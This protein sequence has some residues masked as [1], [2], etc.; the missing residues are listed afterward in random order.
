MKR[1]AAIQFP[2]TNTGRTEP[3]SL[4]QINAKLYD[5]DR[6]VR[7]AAADGLDAGLQENARL[8]TYCSTTWSWTIATTAT[9][10]TSTIRWAR[11]TWPTKS[12]APSSTP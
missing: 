10:A 12:A 7:Q 8:L 6:N 3:L 5:A 2:F 4:Q 1:V 11:A 9:C